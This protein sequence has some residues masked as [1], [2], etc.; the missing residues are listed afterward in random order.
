MCGLAGVV[1]FT[2][3]DAAALAPRLAKAK[4]RL[5]PRGPDAAGQW[6]DGRCA[7]VHTRLAIIDLSPGGAQPM[8]RHGRVIAFNGEIYN[9]AALRD[10]LQ[11]EGVV[12]ESRSDTEVLLAGWR[13]WG[14]DLLP[15]LTGMFAF[16]LWDAAAGEL[17]LA[18]D[19]FGK[20]PLLYRHASART[21]FASDLVALERL[22]EGGAALDREALAWLFTLRY[23][24]DPLTIHRGVAKLPAGH[25]LR[26][27]A[28]GAR[29]ERWYDLAGQAP[30]RPATEAEARAGLVETFDSAVADRLVADV[31]LGVFLSGGIDSAL[32]A[33]SMARHGSR[34]RSFTVGFAGA[35][36]YYEERPAARTVADFLGTDHTE[37][38]IDPDAAA[39]AVPDVFTAFDEPFADSSAVPTWL[40]ARETR[41]H[42]TVA[43][44]GDGADEVFGGYR[45][46]QAELWAGLYRGVP[47][48]LRKGL[49]EPLAHALPESKT[50]PLLERARRLRRFVAHAG[51]S[52]SARQAGLLTLLPPEEF[53]A[54][55]ADP[56]GVPDVDARVAGLRAGIAD[57]I[58]AMLAA[59]IGL[60]LVGDMLVKVDRASMA[61]GLEVRCPFLDQRVV[62]AAMAMPGGWKL[63]RGAGKR[64]LRQAF[65]DRLP[66]EVFGRPKKGFELPIA[67]WLTGPLADLTRSAIDPGRLRRQGLFDPVLPQMWYSDLKAGRRDTAEPL[68]TLVA[69]QAWLDHH[70]DIAAIA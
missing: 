20:K 67:Q 63:A 28:E 42:V 70:A 12:F 27:T 7:L 24:P 36:A 19:R 35:A 15:K 69:F 2:G 58:N 54:L 31:P 64:I 53:G 5:A 23:V 61:S 57:P 8:A 14:V 33:A 11:G 10:E 4:E 30:P 3:I 59:D 26:V 65:A 29:L 51:K 40:L 48:P 41:R 1:D 13:R 43:L 46:Y 21:L 60:G 34:V 68:W 16:A 47:A 66:A 55:F 44:S 45:K 25:L 32:V 17:V 62:E 52:D 6:Q 50:H 39:A 37:V 38:A 49:I 9:F 22:N 56:L 18:R